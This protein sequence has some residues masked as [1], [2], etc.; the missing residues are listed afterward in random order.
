M[1]GGLLGPGDARCDVVDKPPDQTTRLPDDAVLFII[2]PNKHLLTPKVNVTALL[3]I[4][5]G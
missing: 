5:K 4:N 1:A 2:S 3:A